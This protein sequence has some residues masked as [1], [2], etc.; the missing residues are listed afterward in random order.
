MRRSVNMAPGGISRASLTAA[1]VVLL[2][3]PAAVAAGTY[4]ETAHGNAER[5]V[6]RTPGL[7][8]GACA[9]CHASERGAPRLA[10]GLW[11]ENDNELC[12]TCHRTEDLGGIFPGWE[13]YDRSSHSTDPRATWPGSFPPARREARAA[14]K[15]VNCHNPHGSS[16]RRGVIPGL[17]AVREGDLCLTCH[18]GSPSALDVARDVRKPYAHSPYLNT[19][20]HDAGEGGDPDRH[21]YAGGNRHAACGDCHNPHAV[22]GGI[23][24]STPGT[25]PGRLERVSRVR[26]VNGAAGIVPLYDYRPANDTSSPVL[27]YEV[28]FKCHSSWTR[29]P[30]GQ[31]DL[32]LLLN[33]QNASY[34]PV[35]GPGK[36]LG[37]DPNA[38]SPGT[39]AA[40]TISCSQCHGSD[41]S[42]VGGP[43]GSRFPNLLRRSYESRSESRVTTP[44]E[45]C[46]GC[47]RF[48]VY[49]NTLADPLTLRASRWNPPASAS[50]HAFHVGARS[51]PCFACHESHGSARFPA[52]IAVGRVPGLQGFSASGSGGSCAATCHAQRTYVVNYPR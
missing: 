13:I 6:L 47:H 3:I 41:D 25:A 52:L 22:T 10:K 2:A 15:C 36:N 35:E 27:E 4:A 29:Q 39:T 45:L 17:L 43:H 44:E 40:S 46:F 18:D 26:V 23:A 33:L 7:A 24:A 21:S 48:E 38:F 51:V 34:H 50:G 49:A 20:R 11:R 31:P 37:I 28:C 1:W 19:D 8:R 32:A 14:G 5:G 9:H 12:F 16:D 30:P 42:Q